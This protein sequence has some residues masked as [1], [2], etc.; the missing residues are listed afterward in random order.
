MLLFLLDFLHELLVLERAMVQRL[1]E[2][3]PVY[4]QECLLLV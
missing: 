2:V 1:L 3:F 4:V